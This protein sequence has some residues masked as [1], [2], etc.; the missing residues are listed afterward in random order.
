[1]QTTPMQGVG[2][3]VRVANFYLALHNRDA[4]R[5][6]VDPQGWKMALG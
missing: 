1:M 4:T 3:E 6:T 5:T 2:I